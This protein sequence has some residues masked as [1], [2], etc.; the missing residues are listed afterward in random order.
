MFG[1][2]IQELRKEY[3]VS[4]EQLAEIMSTTRQAVSKWERGESYPDLD[5]LKDLAIYFNVSIDYLLEY[6]IESTSVKN[7]ISRLDNANKNK[8][9]DITED[10]IKIIVCKNN[11]NFNL[12]F[13]SIEYLLRVDFINQRKTLSDLV[14]DYSKRA[15]EIF[16]KN[17][18]LKVKEIDIQKI[19]IAYYTSIERFDLA[20][21]YIVENHISNVDDLL[22]EIEFELG[23]YD[24]ASTLVSNNFLNSVQQIVNGNIIQARLFIKRNQIKELYELADFSITLIKSLQKQ[25]D[26]LEWVIFSFMA[27]KAT[28]E[29]N[30]GL[31]YSNSLKYLVE[32]NKKKMKVEQDTNSLKFFYNENLELLVGLSDVKESMDKEIKTTFKDT[33]L[34]KSAKAIYQMVFNDK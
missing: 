26:F 33:Q 7:F 18:D 17:N 11:N 27:F 2:K 23:N 20:K 29:Y 25:E 19:I 15:L 31:D 5:R 14:L 10:E 21:E 13:K 6:D 9:L 32:T 24:I 16:P 28:C 22:S 12:L 30:L 1:D 3:K 34:E 8:T 4:Q